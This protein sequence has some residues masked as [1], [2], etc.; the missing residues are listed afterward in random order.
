VGAGIVYASGS[1]SAK[2]QI[3]EFWRAVELFS[4]PSIPRVAPRDRT[5]P[6][7][8]LAPDQPL[9]W[10][11]GHPLA[12]Q[13]IPA[14]TLWRYGVY[15]GVFSLRAVRRILEQELGPDPDAFEERIDGESCL[16]AFSATEQGRPLLD[17]FVVSTCAWATGRTLSPG[18]ESDLWL[19]GAEN[20]L[21]QLAE[22]FQEHF[23]LAED[24][25]VGWELRKKGL[26][27]GRPA[28]LGDLRFQAAHIQNELGAGAFVP[29][30]GIRVRAWLGSKKSLGGGDDHDFLNSF[31]VQD[32]ER[33][34]RQ[35]RRGRAGEGLSRYLSA[36]EEIQRS[37]RVDVRRALPLLYHQLLPERFPPGRW[38]SP[39]HRPLD[40]SQQFA[41]NTVLESLGGRPGL[42]AING[43]PGS[44][45]TTLLRDLV[46]ALVVERARR[47]AKLRTTGAAFEGE[48][49]WRSG[50][51][52]RVISL[53][54]KPFR[55]FE[56]V[57]ASNNNGA[58]ENVTLEIPGR[59]AVD[60]SWLGEVD[61]FA[62]YAERLLGQEAWALIAARLGNK[63][64]RNEFLRRFW[65]PDWDLSEK[66]RAR[67][68]L[69]P[70]HGFLAWLKRQAEGEATVDWKDEVGR[71]REVLAEEEALRQRRPPGADPSL[72]PDEESREKAAP[73]ADEAWALAR[74]RV[75]LAAL[76]LHRAFLMAE[77]GRLRKN[78]QG[79]MD[80]IAGSVPGDAPPKAVAAAWAS[81]FFLIPVVSTTFA[82]FDRLFAHLGREGLGWLLIDE[83]GQTVPQAA[84]GAIWRA[85]RTVT[86]GD[87]R[88]L[89]P[90]VT[91]PLTVQ[92]A[93]RRHYD[94][95]G[96]VPEIWLPGRTSVQEL[97]DR[98]SH[99]GTEIAAEGEEPLWVGAPLR[100]HRRCDEP[101]FGI[102]NRIA[103]GG[104]M[105]HGVSEERGAVDLPPSFWYDVRTHGAEGHWIPA[106]GRV[107]QA[108]LEAIR[109]RGFN[110]R[111]VALLSPF[112]AVARQLR[113]L[114]R[115][116][117]GPV[118]GTIHTMQGKEADVVILV[119]GGDPARPGARAWAS[120]RPNLLN[121]AVSRAR[122][123]LYVVGDRQGWSGY[124]YFSELARSVGGGEEVPAVGQAEIWEGDPHRT[125]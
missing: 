68:E 91:L 113:E 29:E 121:V 24:D 87:P 107:V 25:E 120:R 63:S 66:E 33:V 35:V 26:L 77:A 3:L 49:R 76:R 65:F 17:S 70:R 90:V 50:S 88:Q 96:E 103:Y 73:W 112:R 115:V 39:G 117:D 119:L 48:L 53:W 8:A 94:R 9:P 109:L 111:E 5:Q 13:R 46:A 64:N 32:L 104:L 98:V 38:P 86:V 10:E 84:A 56:I 52:T 79:A 21:R 41:V 124:R 83:A 31:F 100:V 106:E 43:P 51:Y 85:R 16:F 37:R 22:Q 55:G 20:C 18:P 34:A 108:L 118:A 102:S 97:A 47:L 101:M 44:G 14:G 15:G 92:Q 105:V 69:T 82:S 72:Q 93:L 74:T 125:P 58:V 19:D 28:T 67:G 54:R 1:V 40:F 59:A 4:P 62:D 57:V 89:E 7:F 12:R 99:Q 75:F 116:I 123:R 81:F 80:I 6:V 45:K 2:D 42:F 114:A 11:E 60:P 122:H 27:V 36:E 61:Y 71:F 23:A 110:L 95:T 78:L 30:E